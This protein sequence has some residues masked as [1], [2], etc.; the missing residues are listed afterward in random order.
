MF[1]MFKR[2]NPK[3]KFVGWYT[4]GTRSQKHDIHMNEVFRKYGSRSVFLVV[5]VENN[6]P[7]GLPT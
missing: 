1:K 3:E 5:D 2:I 7:M 6:D 4:T